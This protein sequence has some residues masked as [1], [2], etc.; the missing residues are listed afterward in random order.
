M[1]R[2]AACLKTSRLNERCIIASLP[3]IVAIGLF[4]CS[5]PRSF[6]DPYDK[7]EA[8]EKGYYPQNVQKDVD[9]LF[10]VDNS[11]SMAEHQKNL[12]ANFP[13]L[14]EALRTD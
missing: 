4:A 14:I 8:Q 9:L 7:T 11:G 12:V 5:T 3:I 13:K 6:E 1:S 10:V 2:N